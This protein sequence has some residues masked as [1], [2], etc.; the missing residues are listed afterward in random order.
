PLS[1]SAQKA[2]VYCRTLALIGEPPDCYALD[3][4][5]VAGGKQHDYFFH[6]LGEKMVAEGVE[7]GPKEGGSLAGP[8]IRWGD[9]IG[10]DGDIKGHPNKPYW[11]A[12]PGNGYG[13]LIDPQRAKPTG[14]WHATWTVGEGDGKLTMTPAPDEGIEALTAWGPGILPRLPGAQFMVL[15]RR[16]SGAQDEGLTSTFACAYEPWGPARAAAMM[17]AGE[18]A[19]ELTDV[20]GELLHLSRLGVL[21]WKAPGAQAKLTLELP[22]VPAGEYRLELAHYRSPGYGTLEVTLDG[23]KLGEIEGYAD[24]SRPAQP[25]TY[26]G[27]LQL[28]TGSHRLELRILRPGK[29]GH[30]WFGVQQVRLLRP[31]GQGRQV[32]RVRKLTPTPA[33]AQQPWPAAVRIDLAGDRQDFLATAPVGEV[34]HAGEGA[35]AF[36]WSGLVYWRQAAG[37]PRRVVV[38]G[39]ELRAPGLEVHLRPAFWHARVTRVDYEHNLAYVDGEL[40]TDGRLQGALALFT[41]PDRDG[42]VGYSRAAAYRIAGVR[43]EKNRLALHLGASPTLGVL[44]VDSADRGNN[45]FASIIPHEY[46]RGLGRPTRFF[47][48]KL[49]ETAEGGRVATVVKADYGAPCVVTV[50]EGSRLHDGQRLYIRDLQEGDEVYIAGWAA[51]EF[52]GG[53]PSLAGSNTDVVVT[54]EGREGTLKWR[55]K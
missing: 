51:V 41:R 24:R 49:L 37:E 14:D 22:A 2:T 16:T 3:L 46:M 50:D 29:S 48:G 9:K 45:R 4:F 12:P 47:R 38:I 31:G 19:R 55:P 44:Q 28:G 5:R 36:T 52:V 26:F 43:R 25:P 6:A 20:P 39:G 15:R 34:G 17:T 30:Y 18:M 27:P 32:L 35:Q 1:Y 13:F 23:Q 11:L 54:V 8:D 21:L 33:K 53:R 42:Q 40:P 7:F 10:N